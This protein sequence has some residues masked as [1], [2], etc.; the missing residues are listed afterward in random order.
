M[1]KAGYFIQPNTE[2][3]DHIKSSSSRAEVLKKLKV[4]SPSGGGWYR[5]LNRYIRYNSIDISHFNDSPWNKGKKFNLAPK[6]KDEDFFK[7]NSHASSHPLKRRFLRQP[8]V[9]YKCS[10]CGLNSWQ[11]KSISLHLDH[12]NGINNDNRLENL[13][14]LCPNCHSQTVTYCRSQC[15]QRDSN[16]QHVVSKTTSSAS[17][18][19]PAKE[20]PSN[21]CA[22]CK[23]IFHKK[24]KF[25]SAKCY[26]DST[27]SS[28]GGKQLWKRKVERP[29]KEILEEEIKSTTFVELGRKYGVSNTAIKK[30]CRYYDIA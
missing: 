26:H 15:G 13:R 24:N 20:K 19:M 10:E 6:I 17:W 25:C 12:K 22:F 29:S 18:D 28:N 2:I 11:G 27:H 30:W 7:E 21:I 9:I 4:A 14:L 3:N 5:I 16:P 1:R 23:S 8:G